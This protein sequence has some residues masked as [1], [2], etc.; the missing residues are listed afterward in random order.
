[1]N[2]YQIRNMPQYAKYILFLKHLIV[3]AS[4]PMGRLDSI[5]S[6]PDVVKNY[7]EVCEMLVKK[8]I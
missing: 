3:R 4:E 8:Q 2:N 6:Y 1:M 7:N 5:S